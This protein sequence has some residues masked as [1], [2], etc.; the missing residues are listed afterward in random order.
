V[1]VDP[2]W[3]PTPTASRS[4]DDARLPRRPRRRRRAPRRPRGPM[5]SPDPLTYA[6]TFG[7]IWFHDGRPLT[8]ADCGTPSRDPRRRESV[9]HRGLSAPCRDRDPRRAD[10]RLR[11]SEPFAPFLSTMARA[12]SRREARRAATR[13]RGAGPYRIDDLSPDGEAV[14]RHTTGITA[15]P[16][17]IRAVTSSS[18]PDSNVRF[19]ELKMGSVNFRAERRRPDLLPAASLPGR[20]VVEEG[21]GERHLPRIQSARPCTVRR[22]GAARDR[23]RDRPGDD[24]PDDLEGARRPRL[25]DPPPGR[26]RT[27]RIFPR[28]R[29]D[30][31]GRGDSSTTPGYPIPTARALSPASG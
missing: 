5:E 4:P 31:Y 23:P 28:C 18:L 25:L 15:G 20:L 14:F 7:R 6:S 9:P 8:S 13:A 27:I 10:G 12:S 29:F 19:L 22:E 21:P 24:R 26:G 1:N 2:R 3:R 11:L 30:P 16:P 17:A